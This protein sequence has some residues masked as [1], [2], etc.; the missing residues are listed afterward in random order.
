M[1][2]FQIRPKKT[3]NLFNDLG[4]QFLSIDEKRRSSITIK[5]R[6]F[7]VRCLFMSIIAYLP[8]E[9]SCSHQRRRE[10]VGGSP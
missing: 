6:R 4:W 1:M 3:R 9:T 2:R 8:E 7:A 5:D 10:P